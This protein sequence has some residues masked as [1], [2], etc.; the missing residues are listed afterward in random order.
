MSVLRNLESKIAGL[1]EGT[2]GRV[3][4]SEVR[5][6]ELARK[7][8]REMDEHKTV[9]L[10]RT[11]VPNEYVIWLSP[12]DRSRYAGME[13]SVAD[14]L[15]GHLLEHARRERYALAARPKIAWNTDDRLGLGEFGI[16]ARLVRPGA[17]EGEVEQAAHGRTMVHSS[18][19]R[20]QEPLGQER[21]ARRGRAFVHAEGKRLPVG[22]AGAVLGRS[23]DCDIVL[24]DT[25]VSRRHAEIRPAATGWTVADLGSTNGVRVNGRPAS[26]VVAL[27]AGDRLELGTAPMTFEVE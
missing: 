22:S 13:E 7:L 14:E 27:S 12:E 9:S 25:N 15:A 2:F 17:D 3:F 23:R 20:I 16:Q 10:K 4:K 5:P 11:Y 6:V 1:V 8:S 21:R 18:A 19:E 26:G 24:E